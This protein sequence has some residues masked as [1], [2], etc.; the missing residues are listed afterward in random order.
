[1]NTLSLLLDLWGYLVLRR[2]LQLGAVLLM[3]LISSVAELFSLAAIIPL[4]A[5]LSEPQ[6]LWKFS[7]VKDMSA[8]MGISSAP[9]LLLPATILF[10]LGALIAALVRLSSLW[11]N[12]RLSAVI[13]SDLSADAFFLTLCQPYEVHLQRNSSAL[14][15]TIS[16]QTTQV[17]YVLLASLQ[18]VTAIFVA[19][20]L[21]IPLF[22]INFS[23]TF[24]SISLFGAAYL[25]LS[26]AARR[27]LTVNSM[28]DAEGA[29]QSLKLLQE[30]FGSVRNIILECRQ[31]ASVNIY[32]GI[33]RAMRLR[34]AQNAFLRD[35]PR[36]ALEALGLL[37]MAAIVFIVTRRQDTVG[38]V[39][40]LLGAFALGAQRLLPTLQQIY[41]NWSIIKAYQ[42]ALVDV[43]LALQQTVPRQA[44]LSN[45]KPAQLQESV[46]LFGVYFRYAPEAPWVL[47]EIDLEIWRG[48][49]IGLIGSTGSGKSTLVDLL[50]GL[51]DPTAGKILI[52]GNDLHD[53]NQPD[54]LTAWRA[55]IAHVPQSIFLADSSIAENIAFGIPK[56]QI[57]L[58]R[59]RQAAEQA[60]IAG[61]IESSPEGY[62]TFVGERG[63]R[64]SG[65]QRQRIG[66]ARALYKRASVIVL[67]EA[68]SALDTATEG[69]VMGALESLSRELTVVM[70]AHRLST[71]AR[72]DRIFELAP[73]SPI[74]IKSPVELLS[75][76]LI[77]VS[78]SS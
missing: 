21:L 70:I 17:M 78:T 34:Q 63:I 53:S 15:T 43:L 54:R 38:A 9:D 49:R 41:S 73:G 46:R 18:L 20:G 62:D 7:P 2:R 8:F 22:L 66:I 60:Q 37:V 77:N 51:L 74:R 75:S 27:N 44:L 36:F 35:F 67:D 76:E 69:A 56:E 58:E 33:D 6:Q 31:S 5:V 45:Q 65:G 71:L 30:S 55:A 19:L 11:L 52:D 59:V 3:M 23:A 42:S 24:A 26:L 29:K 57:D 40:P 39:I 28:L 48:E 64:L 32:A 12:T 25:F 4:L 68:T 47:Q 61:F 14:I 1:M 13:S 50:M 10:G 72:C 16:A